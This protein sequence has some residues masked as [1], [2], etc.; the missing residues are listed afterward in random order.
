MVPQ[1][2]MAAEHVAA[3]L[4]VCVNHNTI[5]QEGNGKTWQSRIPGVTF[6]LPNEW[7]NVVALIEQTGV[8]YYC[9]MSSKALLNGNVITYIDYDLDVVLYPNGKVIVVDRDEF[10]ENSKKYRYPPAVIEN[11]ESALRRLLKRIE[12]RDTP[13]TDK[14]VME[15]YQLWKKTF[16]IR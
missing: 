11:V 6:F 7:Y 13:F 9:N 1:E 8:R 15:Y 14:Y 12:V 2:Q 10:V 4:M 5:I 3:E 16:A